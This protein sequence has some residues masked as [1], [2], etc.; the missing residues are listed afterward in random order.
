MSVKGKVPPLADGPG[1][2]N[3]PEVQSLLAWA[4]GASGLPADFGAFRSLGASDWLKIPR[5]CL[6][7]TSPS[8][9]A[10][11]WWQP[12]G[13]AIHSQDMILGPE[14]WTLMLKLNQ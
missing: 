1:K 7:Q 2:G 5:Q 9:R 4:A 10:L 11:E 8:G 12:L 13:D 14:S 3:W 6:R